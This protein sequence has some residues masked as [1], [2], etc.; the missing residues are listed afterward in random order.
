M[1][2]GDVVLGYS[3][4]VVEAQS[5]GGELFGAERLM[6]VVAEGPTEP[7]ALVDYVMAVLSEFT[8]GTEPYDDLTLVAVRC[9][10]E[11]M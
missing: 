4:G 3:D 8:S 11:V 2:R 7:E 6:E 5:T 9:D 1:E 10:Q